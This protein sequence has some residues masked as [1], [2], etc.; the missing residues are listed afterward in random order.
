MK[1]YEKIFDE[2]GFNHDETFAGCEQYADLSKTIVIS[3]LPENEEIF[4]IE[5][6]SAEESYLDNFDLLSIL[7][8]IATIESKLLKHGFVF[9]K[10]YIFALP[11]EREQRR[12]LSDRNRKE[13]E[14]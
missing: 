14:I 6:V 1:D 11:N 5:Y 12:E 3:F 9:C 4:D 2:L 13:R 7:D 8:T 10:N